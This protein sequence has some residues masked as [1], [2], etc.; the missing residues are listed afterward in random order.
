MALLAPAALTAV[1]NLAVSALHHVNQSAL[2]LTPFQDVKI[3]KIDKFY[4]VIRKSRQIAS[5][6]NNHCQI[7][8]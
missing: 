7:Q 1:N 4:E 2:S 5:I 6:Y 3:H 8:R